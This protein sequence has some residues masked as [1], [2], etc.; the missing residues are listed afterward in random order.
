MRPSQRFMPLDWKLLS[1]I[2]GFLL[3]IFIFKVSYFL[4]LKF[5]SINPI[6][7]IKFHNFVKSSTFQT[8]IS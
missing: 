7:S 6:L 2:L 8:I 4:I 1:I 3:I 5:L